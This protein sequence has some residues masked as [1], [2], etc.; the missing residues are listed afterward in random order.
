M[1]KNWKPNMNKKAQRSKA[2]AWFYNI[3]CSWFELIW[4][5]KH[6]EK[7]SKLLMVVKGHSCAFLNH[8]YILNKEFSQPLYHRKCQRR[9]VGCFLKLS[10]CEKERFVW[11]IYYCLTYKS[12]VLHSNYLFITYYLLQLDTGLTIWKCSFI[13]AQLYQSSCKCDNYFC[14]LLYSPK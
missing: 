10:Q 4:T 9:G 6:K 8:E 7:T 12:N 2:V 11:V 14:R 13:L 1:H 3:S 5:S